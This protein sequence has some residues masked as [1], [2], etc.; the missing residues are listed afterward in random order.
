MSIDVKVTDRVTIQCPIPAD[1]AHTVEFTQKLNGYVN[2][3]YVLVGA[4]S[5]EQ[6]Q[7]DPYVVGI[8]VTLERK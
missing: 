2:T 5:I 1:E 3:G 7:R 4:T 8:K 6:G